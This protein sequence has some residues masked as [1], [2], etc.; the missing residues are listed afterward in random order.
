MKSVI[1]IEKEDFR[2]MNAYTVF[3]SN[4]S[5]FYRAKN[6]HK[7][8]DTLFKRDEYVVYGEVNGKFVHIECK[9]YRSAKQLFMAIQI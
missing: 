7:Y 2:T 3:S 5:R 4:G 8:K 9:N 1:A 6:N